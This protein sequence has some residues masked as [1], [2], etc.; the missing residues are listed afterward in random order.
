MASCAYVLTLGQRHPKYA[1][2]TYHTC[3]M[4]TQAKALFGSDRKP[5]AL[6]CGVFACV[7]AHADPNKVVKITR[8]ASDVAGLMKGQSLAQVP[9]VYANHRLVG[10]PRWTTPRVRTQRWQEWPD[11]PKAFAMVIEKLIVM[12]GSEKSK[13]NQRLRRML[14]LEQDEEEARKLIAAG[15]SKTAPLSPSAKTKT[16]KRPTIGEMAKTVCPKKPTAEAKHCEM[17]MAELSKLRNALSKAGIDWTDIHAGN[18]GKDAKGRWKV[19]DLGASK[20]TLDEDPPTLEGRK[21]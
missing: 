5:K 8:D 2:S 9:K 16:Y 20:T 1:P 11:Q 21:R 19:L 12:T 6:G 18:I 17:R 15:G 10:N 14:Q 3:I 13:W 4:P 7:F